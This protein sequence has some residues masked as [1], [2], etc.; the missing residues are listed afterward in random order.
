M[1]GSQ[2]SRSCCACNTGTIAEG[3]QRGCLMLVTRRNMNQTFNPH[4]NVT[5]Q[6][7]SNPF[8]LGILGFLSHEGSFI[9][10]PCSTKWLLKTMTPRGRPQTFRSR[11]REDCYLLAVRS[12]E[13]DPE[14]RIASDPRER[15]GGVDK[16]GAMANVVHVTK[17]HRCHHQCHNAI[18]ACC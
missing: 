12:I 7:E 16:L 9:D 11:G 1:F 6:T 10:I 15:V 4:V 17:Q 5:S 3:P 18:V 2:T 8:Q 14:T 13:L